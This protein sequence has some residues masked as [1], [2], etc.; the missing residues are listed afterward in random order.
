MATE[1]KGK[2]VWNEDDFD[3]SL[4]HPGDYVDAQVVMNTMNC[5]PP[6][7]MGL[8]CAQMGEP[9]SHK[10]DT[11]A[12]KL[13]PTFATFKVVEGDFNEGIWKFCRFCFAGETSERG[14]DPAYI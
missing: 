8:N 10:E 14:I 3:F 13:R 4:V 6:A 11:V 9:Y 7:R 1:F 2:K 5:M 12:G